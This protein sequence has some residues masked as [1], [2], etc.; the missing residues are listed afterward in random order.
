MS[1]GKGCV[2]SQRGK[3]VVSGSIRLQ[4]FSRTPLAIS[5]TT[6]QLY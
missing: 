5:Q 6:E 2:W 1:A 4:S 3:G